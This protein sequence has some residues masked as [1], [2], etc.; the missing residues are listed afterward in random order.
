V[1]YYQFY[2]LNNNM[3]RILRSIAIL[4]F[5][6]TSL[7]SFSQGIDFYEGTYQEAFKLA[8][9]QDKLVFVDAY[10]EWCGPCKRMAATTFKDTEVGSFFNEQFIN[11]KIDMEK[12]QGLTF[13]NEYPVSAFPTL[14]FIDGAGE[15]VHK[16]VGG[17]KTA[18]FLQLGQLALRKFDNSDKYAKLYEEGNRDF[19]LMIKYV[20]SLNKVEKPSLK[21][22]NE[23]LRSK[24]AISDQQMAEFLYE[25]TTHAD[26][27]IFDMMVDH[28]SQIIKIKGEAALAEKVEEACCKTVE[29]A[30]EFESPELLSSAKEKL[31]KNAKSKY[32]SFNVKSDM[33]YYLGTGDVDNYLKKSKEYVSK[34]IKKNPEELRKM[35]ID[36]TT[37]FKDNPEALSLAGESIQK[38]I[39]LQDSAESRM[40]YATILIHA[41][42][43]SEALKQANQALEI[44]K[45]NGE[46]VKKIQGMIQYLQSS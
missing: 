38:S 32:K 29:K 22:S 14:L 19:D 11:L 7:C 30:I 9:K 35:A 36:L 25:A 28:K 40:T 18:D 6:L 31:K 44:A 13:R 26:S 41:E 21:I 2:H 43:K 17:K 39:K 3:E 15:V 34:I 8:E 37:E 24:P 20:Q 45:D 1:F 4:A 27:R 33:D 46:P 5:I 42:Q 12:G 10:A 23:Y 16:A